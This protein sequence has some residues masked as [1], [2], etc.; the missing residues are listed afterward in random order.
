MAAKSAHLEPRG[1][2]ASPMGST[3]SC[4]GRPVLSAEPRRRPVLPARAPGYLS[5]ALDGEALIVIL[6]RH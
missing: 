6:V 2:P 5:N 3:L 4:E 1:T